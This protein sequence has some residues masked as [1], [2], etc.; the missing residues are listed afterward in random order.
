[1][2]KV[3]IIIGS[4]RPGR[5]GEAVARWVYDLAQQR[6]DA[7][8]ELV[9]IK[10]FNLPLLDEPVPP[11]Q[12]Q[13]SQSHTKV[14]AAKIAPF[15][16]FVFVTP[17]Y[18]HGISGVGMPSRRASDAREYPERTAQSVLMTPTFLINNQTQPTSSE[19]TEI[20]FNS[21]P[22][23]DQRCK[24]SLMPYLQWRRANTEAKYLL[25]VPC[26]AGARRVTATPRHA[27]S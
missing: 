19:S 7:E 2:I 11:S 26:S 18:N 15:D 9:D 6:S 25:S 23:R 16:A 17:E 24:K 22:K 10:A 13:Y 27:V 21:A 4:T 3:A 14:W 5:N 20:F 1:M 8:F 12:G